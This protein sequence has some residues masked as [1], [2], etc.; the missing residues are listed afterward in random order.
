MK[1]ICNL[2]VFGSLVLVPMGIFGGIQTV[3]SAIADSEITDVQA[4]SKGSGT[5]ISWRIENADSVVG[6]N[7][8]RL[9]EKNFVRVNPAMVPG[10]YGMP[11][12]RGLQEFSHFDRG[13]TI[14]DTYKIEV[15]EVGSAP[16]FS[17]STQ[18]VYSLDFN[19][20]QWFGRDEPTSDTILTKNLPAGFET[21]DSL[22]DLDTQRWVASQPGV[23]IMIRERGLTRVSSAE[24][25]AAGFDINSS[26]DFWQLYLDGI[27]QAIKVGPNGDYI[28]F[29]GFGVDTVETGDNVYFLVVGNSAGKRI[30][31]KHIRRISSTVTS[32]NF[33]TSLVRT[34]KF[35]YWSKLLNGDADNFFGELISTTPSLIP[36]DLPGLDQNQPKSE[37]VIDIQG[38]TETAH[39]TRVFVNGNELSSATGNSRD[40]RVTAYGI[41]TSMLQTT[42]NVIELRSSLTG[43]LNLLALLTI[44]YTRKYELANGKLHFP[45]KNYRQTRITGVTSDQVRV[46]D[47]SYPDEPA[48]VSNAAVTPDPGGGFI[49]T[50]PGTRG[51]NL[52]AVE[53]SAILSAASIKQ[54]IPSAIS[55][56]SNAANF[57]IITN[58]AWLSEAEAWA[59]Y[60]AGQGLQSMV[61][62]IQDVFDEYNYGR[63]R[64]ESI[65]SFLLDAHSNWATPP[66]YVLLLGDA[67]YDPRD[68]EQ[69]GDFNFMP[70]KLVDTQYEETTSDDTLSDFNN[71]GLAEI[72]IG[73]IP[74]RVPV[75]VTNA[76]QKVMTF[77]SSLSTAPSRGSLCASDVTT[78][79]FDFEA[80]C[81]RLQDQ[82]P[83]S[84]PQT[85]INRGE[86]NA[87]SLLLAEM[88]AGRYMV[89]YSGHGTTG[90]W[91]STSFFGSGD[92]AVLTNQTDL[93]LYTM[94]TCL[95]GYFIRPVPD[96][97]SETLL[98]TT[99]GGAVAVWSSSGS[100]T[101]DVQEIMATRFFNQIGNGSAHRIGDLINDAKTTIIA[102]RDVRLSWVLLGDP[103][104]IASPAAAPA[105]SKAG[106]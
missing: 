77:E 101:P 67:T 27:Q 36:F 82:L 34:R 18:S 103:A 106:F 50:L 69:R 23:K 105:K 4:V 70:A 2:L 62:D 21:S 97:L 37:V 98:R 88:N 91:A 13:G 63:I 78:Q 6:F 58:R 52:Y 7:I 5:M 68:Y 66:S 46:F 60:R 31:P 72:P 81:N 8:L 32:A 14:G 74:A 30:N 83:A 11:A 1:Y 84:I 44:N 33:R 22:A 48:E 25:Q 49:I 41:P 9:K 45:S 19:E 53:P 95:N 87:K 29:Y 24:L 61:V 42:G 51:R 12:V 28:E 10:A 85:G 35:L 54:N 71:D 94:L 104:T 40:R 100:T 15:V 16:Y 47:L 56:P 76:L 3:S 20:P 102:G 90:V 80:L 86:P 93:S 89:N 38:F 73:R 64:S 39:S 99:S 79:G 75:D 59:A 96:S 17:R 43:D 57:L 92:A 26:S 65:R 55:S